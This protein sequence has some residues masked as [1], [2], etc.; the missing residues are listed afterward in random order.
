MVASVRLLIALGL[1]LSSSIQPAGRIVGQTTVEPAPIA[2][3]AT[4]VATPDVAQ[5]TSPEPTTSLNSPI[6]LPLPAAT[7]PPTSTPTPSET[8]TSSQKLPT[9]IPTTPEPEPPAVPS[10]VAANQKPQ[11]FVQV[12]VNET[13]LVAK[14]QRFEAAILVN[15]VDASQKLAT[16]GSITVSVGLPDGLDY[17]ANDKDQA[18]CQDPD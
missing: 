2:E 1:G 5:V 11:V 15:T 17:I 14:G 13:Q 7:L 10:D 8:L 9:T 6:A 4:P 3:V 16:Q 18:V 12:V